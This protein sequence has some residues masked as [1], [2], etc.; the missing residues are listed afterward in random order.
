MILKL[1]KIQGWLVSSRTK[2]Q[3]KV[4]LTGL[5]TVKNGKEAALLCRKT[6]VRLKLQDT[7]EKGLNMFPRTNKLPNARKKSAMYRLQIGS[8]SPFEKWFMGDSLTCYL[9][10]ICG[11]S[12]MYFV[13][14]LFSSQ[15]QRVLAIPSD[16]PTSNGGSTMALLIIF[17]DMPCMKRVY[18]N[19]K[20]AVPLVGSQEQKKL[21]GP[22]INRGSTGRFVFLFPDMPCMKRVYRDKKAS[23]HCSA[24]RN[25]ERFS[26]R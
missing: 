14:T 15:E 2:E 23:F 21:L 9:H 1:W 3:K 20:K 22:L 8:Q 12:A 10:F 18:K 19:K 4:G 26:S 17:A 16:K 6:S 13:R 11:L 24:A 5:S 25:K 7:G